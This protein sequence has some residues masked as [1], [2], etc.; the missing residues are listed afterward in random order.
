MASIAI[1]LGALAPTVSRC[2][3]NARSATLPMMEVCVS[4]AGAPSLLVFKQLP[5]DP[6]SKMKMDHCPLCVM[7]ADG[8]GL[9]PNGVYV[10]SIM[11]LRHAVPTLF[12]RAPTPLHAWTP[13]LARAPPAKL[14]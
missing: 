10:A 7:Q 13:A 6:S 4:R 8:H 14:A 12:L 9:P 1:L 11:F 3:T 2:L 5:D